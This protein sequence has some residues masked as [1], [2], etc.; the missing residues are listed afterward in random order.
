MA[1]PKANLQV[2][3]TN[4]SPDPLLR[5][6]N[7]TKYSLNGLVL[8]YRSERAFREELW[9]FAALIPLA[10]WLGNN[11]FEY[12]LLIGSWV[13]VMVVEL[14]NTAI[15]TTVDRI[16]TERHDLSGRAKDVASA[17]VMVSIALALG[18]WLTIIIG[19]SRSRQSN[20]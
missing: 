9:L 3:N 17:A 4:M 14:L 15:E 13:I 8:T 12:I 16:G 2:K 5:L 1:D 19:K 11:Q 7:A 20:F 6:H 10:I 18:I